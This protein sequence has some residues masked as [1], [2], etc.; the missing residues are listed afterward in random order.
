V[1]AFVFETLGWMW[2]GF[3]PMLPVAIGM[4]GGILGVLWAFGWD[5]VALKDPHALTFSQIIR[6]FNTWSGSSYILT[7]FLPWVLGL[8]FLAWYTW[9]IL[10]LHSP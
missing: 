1:I 2:A 10:D 7:I 6:E 3:R 5:L 8:S 4:A 9:H